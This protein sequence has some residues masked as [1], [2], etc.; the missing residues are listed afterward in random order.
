MHKNKVPNLDEKAYLDYVKGL[1]GNGQVDLPE[2]D[3]KD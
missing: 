2:I 3:K 1:T